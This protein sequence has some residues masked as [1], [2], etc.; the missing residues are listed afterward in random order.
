MKHLRTTTAL[1]LA[2][3]FTLAGCTHEQPQT[4]VGPSTNTE[5]SSIRVGSWNLKRLGDSTNKDHT[6]IAG[7][8][9]RN[10][11]LMAVI[12]VVTVSSPNDSF[13]PVSDH[14]PIV[15]MISSLQDDDYFPDA[16]P[17]G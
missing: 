6:S 11:D 9:E 15:P 12:E 1:A 16:G 5:A 2:L 3:L 13:E 17:R 4:L 14:L 7:V 8:A 10:F